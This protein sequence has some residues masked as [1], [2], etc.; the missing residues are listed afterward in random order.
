[1]T[2]TNYTCFESSFGW[3]G[4][5]KSDRGITRVTFGAPTE[6]AITDRL[7][8]GFARQTGIIPTHP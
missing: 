3:V 5:A 7:R 6:A 1:M 2:I 4:V 8:N